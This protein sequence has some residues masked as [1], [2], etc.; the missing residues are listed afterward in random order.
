MIQ[1]FYCSH[2]P[3]DNTFCG[4]SIDSF[5]TPVIIVGSVRYEFKCVQLVKSVLTSPLSM[6]HNKNSWQ[7]SQAVGML[8]IVSWN[9]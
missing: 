8:M 3:S 2:S 7:I 4:T 1:I 6:G 9:I 5:G